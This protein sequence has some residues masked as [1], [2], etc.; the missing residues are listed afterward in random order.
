MFWMKL[1]MELLKHHMDDS[2][3][4]WPL[5]LNSENFKTRL[6]NMYPSIT[7]TVENP[8]IVYENK[9]KVEIL[10]FLDVKIILHQDNSVESDIHYKPMNTH[11]YLAYDSAHPDHTKKNIPYS[12][13]ERI[14]VFVSNP[15]KVIICLDELRQFLK[16]LS[17]TCNK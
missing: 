4:F 8:E 17:R 13:A 9:K 5:K 10:N 7:F 16:E 12:L 2:F 1:L 11:N 6:N 14:I 15:E 3:I